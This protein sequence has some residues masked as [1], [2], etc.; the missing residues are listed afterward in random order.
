LDLAR[1]V[2]ATLP[3]IEAAAAVEQLARKEGNPIRLVL[4][5]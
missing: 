2:S 5:S 3:L 4:R 1:S